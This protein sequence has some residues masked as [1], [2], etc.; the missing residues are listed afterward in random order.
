MCLNFV[1]ALAEVEEEPLLSVKPSDNTR[2]LGS[3]K[4]Q[5]VFDWSVKVKV[6][7]IQGGQ[8]ARP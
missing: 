1:F 7:R 4:K 2:R 3:C 8:S 5:Y 6:V